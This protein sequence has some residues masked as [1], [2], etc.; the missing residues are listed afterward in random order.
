MN[1]YDYLIKDS[2][3]LA[4]VLRGELSKTGIKKEDFIS[5]NN[6]IKKKMTEILMSSRST[7]G[8][9]LF[10]NV[11]DEGY[12]PNLL[13]KIF[14]EEDSKDFPNTTDFLL[15]YLGVTNISKIAGKNKTTVTQGM[16]RN[17][18]DWLKA[19][20][21]DEWKR[22]LLTNEQCE[23]VDAFEQEQH[24]A[25][26]RKNALVIS[27]KLLAAIKYEDCSQNTYPNEGTFNKVKELLSN[28]VPYKDQS[29]LISQIEAIIKAEAHS[30]DLLNKLNQKKRRV[31]NLELAGPNVYVWLLGLIQDVRIFQKYMAQLELPI[32]SS[33]PVTRESVKGLSK[34]IGRLFDKAKQE[35]NVDLLDAIKSS[36]GEDEIKSYLHW[37]CQ[38][39]PLQLDDIHKAIADMESIIKQM[40]KGEDK[41][42]ESIRAKECLKVTGKNIWTL[43]KEYELTDGQ[44]DELVSLV[45]EGQNFEESL[46]DVR[47]KSLIATDLDGN[48]KR[49]VPE[50]IAL[51]LGLPPST[52]RNRINRAKLHQK[53]SYEEITRPK[54][55][56]AHQSPR[57][58]DT[59]GIFHVTI[60]YENSS[61]I[62]RCLVK[63][64]Y[65]SHEYTTRIKQY[66]DTYNKDG[67]LEFVEPTV[68]LEDGITP[69]AYDFEQ[70]TLNELKN[71][72]KKLTPV[73]NR[74]VGS[75]SEYFLYE[76]VLEHYPHI[77]DPEKMRVRYEMIK[78]GKLLDKFTNSC[79]GFLQ[80][81]FCIT[82]HH[83]DKYSGSTC[84][85]RIFSVLSALFSKG[86]RT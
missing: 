30:S 82:P 31:L 34:A 12:V 73:F 60:C 16:K 36:G 74:E 4:E 25:E 78:R 48:P 69:A 14:G 76:E 40:A 64:G 83:K 70:N 54:N 2:Q 85:L 19:K 7:F 72:A 29:E 67:N 32:P 10:H 58:S 27:P 66:K 6:C 75:Y 5:S 53:G 63:I 23:F 47:D 17:N 20:M 50:E 84:W 45:K 68:L 26:I 49:I 15:D 28:P 22:D 77:L 21:S 38:N 59:P 79:I 24:L 39:H 3:Q 1:G 13:C 8:L 52:I 80:A 56:P 9:A 42:S 62:T 11:N 37:Y 81:C 33:K 18:L 43:K 71:G 86:I 35:K 44:I 51:G 57:K 65:T 55:Q 61:G 41:R 46:V